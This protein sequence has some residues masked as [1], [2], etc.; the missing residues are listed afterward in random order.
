MP[1]VITPEEIRNSDSIWN[2]AP[3]WYPYGYETKPK[4]ASYN[5]VY[6]KPRLPP[7]YF[8]MGYKRYRSQMKTWYR[9]L[10][11]QRKQ[12]NEWHGTN[13]PLEYFHDN[14]ERLPLFYTYPQFIAKANKYARRKRF[15]LVNQRNRQ[16]MLQR[17]QRNREIAQYRRRLIVNA[18]KNKY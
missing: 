12:Y 2:D 10:E 4:Y 3:E 15:Q 5:H 6:G 16:A 11:D 1:Y 18:H 8:T 14:G 13:H 17:I 7:I 9:N